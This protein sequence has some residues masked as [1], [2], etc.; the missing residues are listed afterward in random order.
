MV[1]QIERFRC[2]SIECLST[3]RVAITYPSS[4]HK[5]LDQWYISYGSQWSGWPDTQVGRYSGDPTIIQQMLSMPFFY[6]DF[7][8][9]TLG[10]PPTQGE[11]LFAWTPLCPSLTY[12][13]STGHSSHYICFPFVQLAQIQDL[14][15]LDMAVWMFG[16]PEKIFVMSN[17]NWIQ[18]K[19][20][21][22][23]CCES[24]M[25]WDRKK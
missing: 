17:N 16:P 10:D 14:S 4:I 15:R 19:P 7:G 5:K 24:S 20:N 11:S 25:R 21:Q 6:T 23:G 18:F 12:L 8:D 3:K 9:I 22:R 2:L 1:W 13:F